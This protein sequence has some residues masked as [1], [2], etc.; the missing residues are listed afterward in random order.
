MLITSVTFWCRG[1]L[2]V[3]EATV[4][5]QGLLRNPSATCCCIRA[6][7]SRVPVKIN[8]QGPISV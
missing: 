6:A 8:G 4:T 7:I 1:L 3:T 5:M 2:T